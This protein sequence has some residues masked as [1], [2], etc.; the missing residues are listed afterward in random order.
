[1]EKNSTNSKKI[2]I[3]LSIHPPSPIHN[4]LDPLSFLNSVLMIL[5]NGNTSCKF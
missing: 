5:T 1:M 2:V 3:F 4:M